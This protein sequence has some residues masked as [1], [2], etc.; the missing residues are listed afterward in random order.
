MEEDEVF[1]GYLELVELVKVARVVVVV[2]QEL[3]PRMWRRMKLFVSIQ[4][5]G[6]ILVVRSCSW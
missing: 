6:F 5:V 2:I 3:N 4:A 1:G